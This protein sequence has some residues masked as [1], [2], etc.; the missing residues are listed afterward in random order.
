MRDFCF[1][2]VREEWKDGWWVTM[3]MMMNERGGFL[4]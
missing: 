3:M 2:R 1:L 4:W